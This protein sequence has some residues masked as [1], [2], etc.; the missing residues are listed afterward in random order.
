MYPQI[1]RILNFAWAASATVYFALQLFDPTR[2]DTERVVFWSIYLLA[3]IGT[4]QDLRIA[5]AVTI[6]QLLVIW[7]MMGFAVSD[8]SFSFFTSQAGGVRQRVD[9]TVINTF[10]GILAPA[11]VLIML[12]IVT[13]R[14]VIWVFTRKPLRRRVRPRTWSMATR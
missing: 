10:F 13:H 8:G 7:S 14:H 4:F 1:F 9:A 5:W 3:A 6:C 12:V 11:T 2:L